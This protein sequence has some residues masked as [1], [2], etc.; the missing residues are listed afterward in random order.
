[1]TTSSIRCFT[2]AEAASANAAST[3]ADA[4]GKAVSRRGECVLALTG[5]NTPVDTYR[6]LAAMDVPW[7]SVQV[8]QTDDRVLPHTE[9]GSNWGMI[10]RTL[11]DPASVPEDRRH[12]MP[13]RA[14]D[15]GTAAA[16]YAKLLRT[17]T[18]DGSADVVLLQLG[19]DGHLAS[20][21]H[22]RYDPQDASGAQVTTTADGAVRMTQT[23]RSLSGAETRVVLATGGAKAEAVEKV[24]SGT[25]DTFAT[26]TFLGSDGLLLLDDDAAGQGR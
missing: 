5:G 6:L 8:V 14:A 9:T 17:L 20:L 24:R 3:V 21:F 11:L 16:D 25:A 2:T 10:C 7:G 23:L 15:P 22:D 1:M 26:R 18:P 19:P 12:P 13:V 4:I